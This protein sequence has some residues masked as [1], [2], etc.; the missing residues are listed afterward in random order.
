MHTRPSRWWF[1]D[2]KAQNKTIF[3]SPEIIHYFT[4]NLGV[5]VYNASIL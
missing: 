3:L 4:V 1:I 5:F 2:R